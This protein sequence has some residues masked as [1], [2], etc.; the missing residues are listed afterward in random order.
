MKKKLKKIFNKIT[1]IE[2]RIAI[3]DAKSA[4]VFAYVMTINIILYTLVFSRETTYKLIC[5]TSSACFALAFIVI[6]FCYIFEILAKTAPRTIYSGFVFTIITVLLW[7]VMPKLLN[8]LTDFNTMDMNA[9]DDLIYKIIM[10]FIVVLLSSDFLIV[11]M[12]RINFKT[13][14]SEEIIHAEESPYAIS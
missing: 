10:R 6:S 5:R 13:C 14:E 12:K 3:K 7:I 4:A 1:D 11:I 2:Y 9:N 8:P